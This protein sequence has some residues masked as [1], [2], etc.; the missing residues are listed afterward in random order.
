MDKLGYS[1]V[2]QVKIPKKNITDK[3]TVGAE[4]FLSPEVL[5]NPEL[6]KQPKNTSLVSTIVSV[7][8]K[9]DNN[10]QLLENIVLS[11]G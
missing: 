1:F 10:F 9:N 4:R 8:N 3:V 11:G 7:I 6:I 2:G 5:F